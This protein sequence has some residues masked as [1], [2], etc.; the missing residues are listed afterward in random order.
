MANNYAGNEYKR[1]I[2][3]FFQAIRILFAQALYAF[4]YVIFR[5]EKSTFTGAFFIQ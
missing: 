4:D 2:L 3:T 5:T 1:D